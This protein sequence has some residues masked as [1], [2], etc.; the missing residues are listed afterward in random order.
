MKILQISHYARHLSRHSERSEESITS[1]SKKAAN[2]GFFGRV[3]LP[4]N[5]VLYFSP[6][7]RKK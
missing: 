2:L 7:P 6:Q 1:E 3:P 4:Q 5:D